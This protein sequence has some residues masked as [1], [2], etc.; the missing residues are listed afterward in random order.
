M[1]VD[2]CEVNKQWMPAAHSVKELWEKLE[3]LLKEAEEITSLIKLPLPDYAYQVLPNLHFWPTQT[4]GP[5]EYQFQPWF[6][7]EAHQA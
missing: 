2:L 3:R 1:F 5:F 7:P 4:S 6:D